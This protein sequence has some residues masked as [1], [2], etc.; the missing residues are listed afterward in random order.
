MSDLTLVER[1]AKL[2]ALEV[3]L[4]WQLKDTRRKITELEHR[5][6]AVTGY[7]TEQ[8]RRAGKPVGVTIHRAGCPRIQQPVAVLDATQAQY[9][10]LKDASFNHACVH[11]RP[12][13]ALGIPEK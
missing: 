7:V 13:T 12:D 3:W 9:T 2:R 8:E 11:C 1:L 6:N 4:D 10:L 5:T